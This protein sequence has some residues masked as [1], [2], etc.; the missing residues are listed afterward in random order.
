MSVQKFLFFAPLWLLSSNSI[1]AI[2]ERGVLVGG[3]VLKSRNSEGVNLCAVL[4]CENAIHYACNLTDLLSEWALLLRSKEMKDFFVYTKNWIAK[5]YNV[6][7]FSQGHK[8]NGFKSCFHASGMSHTI[9]THMQYDVTYYYEWGIQ[10]LDLSFP[11]PA[12]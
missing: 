5:I 6:F 1:Q 12:P 8:R 2:G 7:F 10:T 9:D 11:S 3:R 4:F